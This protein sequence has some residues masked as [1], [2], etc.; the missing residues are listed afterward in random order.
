MHFLGVYLVWQIDF[1]R[2]KM[3]LYSNLYCSLTKPTNPLWL[4]VW[5]YRF[6][7][8]DKQDWLLFSLHFVEKLLQSYEFHAVFVVKTKQLQYFVDH[9]SQQDNNKFRVWNNTYTINSPA[10]YEAVMQ[11]NFFCLNLPFAVRPKK[12][13][14]IHKM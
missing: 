1:D 9:F 14:K 4:R 10:S 7:T 5:G 6:R 13:F 12:R 8:K 2:M 3:L 11:V